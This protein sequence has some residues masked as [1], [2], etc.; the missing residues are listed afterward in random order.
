VPLRGEQTEDGSEILD[1]LLSF[2]GNDL[3]RPDPLP[4]HGDLHLEGMRQ[5]VVRERQAI[6]GWGVR[7]GIEARSNEIAERDLPGAVGI[8]KGMGKIAPTKVPSN[9]PALDAQRRGHL[10]DPKGRGC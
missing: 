8:G 4:K 9:R 6:G 5:R 1:P 2:A 3:E 10:C 7:R